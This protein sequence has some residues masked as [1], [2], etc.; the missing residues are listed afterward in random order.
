VHLQLNE[1]LGRQRPAPAN[2]RQAPLFDPTDQAGP[3]GGLKKEPVWRARRG[4][5]SQRAL[6]GAQPR[7]ARSLQPGGGAGKKKARVRAAMRTRCAGLA[8]RRI[9]IARCHGSPSGSVCEEKLL[10]LG[11]VAASCSRLAGYG[12]SRELWKMVWGEQPLR[13]GG[14]LPAVAYLS[15]DL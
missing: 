10:R 15:G 6:G 8:A 2:A 3:T 13:A 11:P 1:S 9:W 5:G 4:R 7:W 14:A 12:P